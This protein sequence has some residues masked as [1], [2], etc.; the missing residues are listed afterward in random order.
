M[1][2]FNTYQTTKP[3]QLGIF[4]NIWKKRVFGIS[5]VWKNVYIMEWK[6]VMFLKNKGN[7]GGQMVGNE[8]SIIFEV[9]K[10]F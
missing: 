9:N 4:V 1:P 2:N 3:E 5:D 10:L 6:D 7:K 8:F